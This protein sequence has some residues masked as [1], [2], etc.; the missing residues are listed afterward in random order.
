MDK[1]IRRE[2]ILDNYQHPMHK[3]L[4]EDNSYK[5][6]LIKSDSCIDRIDMM[7]KIENGIIKDILFDGEACA[8]CTSA[9][10]IFIR[11][12]IGKDVLYAEKLIDEFNKMI[13]EEEY[14]KELLGELNVYEDLYLQPNRK[15]CA[16]LP[17]KAI[18]KIINQ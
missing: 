11:K 4:I 10:S 18:I 3:G 1:D 5:R 7:M 16:L 17:S 8:I 6:R 12:L 14:D 15:N 9:T 2:I 13:N